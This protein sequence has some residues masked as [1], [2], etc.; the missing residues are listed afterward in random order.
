M[1]TSLWLLL[2][3]AVTTASS[4]QSQ[5][6]LRMPHA[7]PRRPETYLCTTIRLDTNKTHYITGF[8]P[9]AEAGTAHHMLVFGCEE[10]GRREA[11]FSCGE[12]GIVL[13]GTRQ[14]KPCQSGSQVIYAWAKNAPQLTLPEGV[15]FKVGGRKS[16]VNFLVLQVHY[17]SVDRIPAEGDRSGV[18]LH[19][20]DKPQP[21]RAGVYVH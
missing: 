13:P 8:D 6:S 2:D 16:G 7:K 14:A 21:R 1:N 17:A 5:F 4:L 20:T 9:V 12:M 11:L 3:L 15:G 10:P 19:Y 18:M